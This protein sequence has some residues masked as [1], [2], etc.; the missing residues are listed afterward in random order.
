MVGAKLVGCSTGEPEI[1]KGLSNETIT[2]GDLIVFRTDGQLEPCDGGA[3]TP[4]NGDAVSGIALNTVSG[5]GKTVYFVK[6]TRLRILMDSDEAG[7][8][9]AADLVGAC[10]DITG[11][12]G[13][14]QVDISTAIQTGLVANTSQ[15]L[16]LLEAN[17]QGYG[18][19]S[20]TS[21]GLFEIVKR[22]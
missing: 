20:D 11:A 17:P 18:L 2:A 1:A 9:M 22:L 13:A 8:S 7:D 4:A 16:V 12:T 21:I 3:G 6:G 10:F 15:Q 5:S 14:Q 19:D